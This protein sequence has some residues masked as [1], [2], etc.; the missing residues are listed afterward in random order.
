MQTMSNL[1]KILL[2]GRKL[3]T[4]ETL[5]WLV[6]NPCVEVLGV[7]TDSHLEGSPT[8]R[9][10]VQLGIKVIEYEAAKQ[11]LVTGVLAPDLG[12]SILYWRKFSGS[13]L[14]PGASRGMI[15][16]H[17]APLPAYKGCGG[18]N[19]A[20]LDSLE[21]WACTAHYCDSSI[22]TGPIIDVH[23][24]PICRQT[25]T[26]QSLEQLTLRYMKTQ[27]TEVLQRA[28]MSSRIL[29]TTP[30]I[31]G[32]YISRQE[33]EASKEVKAGDDVERKARAFFFPPYEGAWKITNGIRC[34]LVTKTILEQLTPPGTT[35]IFTSHP[36]VLD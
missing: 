11:Q 18:Y 6:A 33:M 31:G 26:A 3:I 29:P 1:V 25:T 24:F 8:T 13:M 30:N 15:N 9:A 22:D 14:L 36:E 16:F 20:I 21:E 2:F 7:V 5:R 34:T 27:I 23:A 35:H 12:V 32:R 17:P 19:F 10:A 4:A 28:I